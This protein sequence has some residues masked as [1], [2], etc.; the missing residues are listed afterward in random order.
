MRSRMLAGLH[1]WFGIALALPL[2]LLI[3]S[4]VLLLH[5]DALFLPRSVTAVSFDPRSPQLMSAELARLMADPGLRQVDAILLATAD[6]P[7]HTVEGGDGVV[8]YLPV[9]GQG[10]LGDPPALLRLEGWLLRLHVELLAGEFGDRVLY[11]LGPLAFGVVLAGATLWWPL[12]RGWR[13]RDLRPRGASRSLQLRHHVTLGGALFLLG[14]LQFGT[15]ALLVYNPQVR[16]WLQEV[17]APRAT[18]AAPAVR[19][20]P[21]DYQAAAQVIFT[22]HPG[23]QATQLA[24]VSEAARL[25]WSVKLRLPGERHPNGRSLIV[26][27]VDAGRVVRLRDARLGG[28]PAV[29]DDWLYGFHIARLW[30]WP[31]LLVWT[32]MS[33]GLAAL[34]VA[35]ARSFFRRNRKAAEPRAVLPPR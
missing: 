29:Y 33:L 3:G 32:L 18:P 25:L 11:V 19:F 15:G 17:A 1:A 8:A 13:W 30:G 26:L 24:P 16:Q 10:P 34:V 2:L 22:L 20:E 28:L 27:D 21:G 4:G 14:G 6:R 7:L 5:K 35:G 9:A 12:R 31:Q 23:A